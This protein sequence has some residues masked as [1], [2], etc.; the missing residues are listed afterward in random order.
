MASFPNIEM[1]KSDQ[2][3]EGLEEALRYP[4]DPDLRIKAAKVLGELDSLSSVES[5]ARSNLEDPEPKVKAAAH[6]A[7]IV[8][9]GNKAD[10]TITYYRK[11]GAYPEPWIM[12]DHRP[13]QIKTQ[14]EVF[15]DIDENDLEE[16]ED[17]EEAHSDA[18]INALVTI[19]QS[20]SDTN[21]K[22]KAIREL[23]KKPDMNSVGALVW[24][25][26]WDDET[27]IQSAA[28]A[29]LKQLYGDDYE[30]VVNSYIDGE[31]D[32]EDEEE[33]EEEIPQSTP[34]QLVDQ[35]NIPVLQEEKSGVLQ[36]V[37]I[38]I[39]VLI[40]VVIFYLLKII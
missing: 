21:L 31:A 4:G 8:L 29:A 24:I 7:L 23:A 34:I 11:L 10:S 17:A 39:L 27:P 25:A 38:G 30:Q 35:T 36:V 2:D 40:L 14:E 32:S 33:D 6:D 22:L 13:V 28:V 18:E 26:K 19:I 9:L 5:L 3:I 16:V 1:L 15:P 20:R 12:E 37:L